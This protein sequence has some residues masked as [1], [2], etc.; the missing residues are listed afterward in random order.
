MVDK[1]RTW[2]STH[3]LVPGMKCV[4]QDEHRKRDHTQMQRQHQSTRQLV[5]GIGTAWCQCC[6][7]GHPKSDL[8]EDS[9][10]IAQGAREDLFSVSHTLRHFF[11]P[12]APV[13]TQLKHKQEPGPGQEHRERQPPAPFHSPRLLSMHAGSQA[14]AT[15]FPLL[16][17]PMGAT[18]GL[19]ATRAKS[20]GSQELWASHRIS[21]H[22]QH[23]C[24]QVVA[25]C[26]ANQKAARVTEMLDPCFWLP[27]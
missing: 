14:P 13:I 27:W 7:Q 1:L 2:V 21:L 16:S 6:Y 24:Q 19:R 8:R 11:F 23:L 26:H 4:A 12:C 5:A 17:S 20:Q 15:P 25:G 22:S 18:L 9:T 3:C 10:P